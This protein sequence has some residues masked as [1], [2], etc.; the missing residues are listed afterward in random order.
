MMRL[1][2]LMM[3]PRAGRSLRERLYRMF[4]RE[5]LHGITAAFREGVRRLWQ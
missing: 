4:R 3:S 1:S 2:L 5:G